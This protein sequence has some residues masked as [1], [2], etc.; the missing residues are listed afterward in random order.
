MYAY[1]VYSLNIAI[2][3]NKREKKENIISFDL[4]YIIFILFCT[5]FIFYCLS[6]CKYTVY[7]VSFIIVVTVVVVAAAVATLISDSYYFNVYH[8][9]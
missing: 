5:H 3:R 2:P 4:L 8:F 6:I 9:F 1:Y 7:V